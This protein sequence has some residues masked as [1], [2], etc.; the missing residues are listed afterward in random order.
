MKKITN[1]SSL[2]IEPKSF[3]QSLGVIK[4]YHDIVSWLNVFV[5]LS[6]LTLNFLCII[7][8]NEVINKII[9]RDFIELS[10]KTHFSDTYFLTNQI[11]LFSHAKHA[12]VN[13]I[14]I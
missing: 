6:N 5:W 2:A 11:A 13:Q 9:N 7:V 14:T 8:P 3:H 4:G 1:F 12:S 10:N